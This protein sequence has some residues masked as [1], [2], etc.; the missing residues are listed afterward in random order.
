MN[1]SRPVAHAVARNARA[2]P[3]GACPQPGAGRAALCRGPVHPVD[4][5]RQPDQVAPGAHQLVLRDRAAGSRTRR[6][7]GRSTRASTTSS[8]RTTK[9]SAPR[10]PRPQRGLLTRPVGTKR[11]TAYR[12]HVDA[13]VLAA[14]RR[15]G[16]RHAWQAVAPIVTLGLQ[17]EQQHQELLLTD[18]LHAFSCNPLLPAYR[19][20]A[21]PALRLAAV[22]APMRWLELPG[23]VVEIGHA[24]DGFRLR[25][26]DAAPRRAA[27][28]LR[29]SPTGW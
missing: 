17:H 5:R 29:A 3:R 27:A 18:I 20:A 19:P 7:T 1:S 4:A 26:R 12:A 22:P 28:A 6:A 15:R 9:R 25:Q 10:H 2:F 16:R 24:G 23:G 8:I 13:A 11:C 14:A 21:A